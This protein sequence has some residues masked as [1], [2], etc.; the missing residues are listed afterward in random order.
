M[1]SYSIAGGFYTKATGTASHAEGSDSIASGYGAHAEGA[2]TEAS[3]NDS[4][5]Q[6]SHTIAA[7]DSQTA[8]GKY[9]DN[10]P[11][12]AFEVGNGTAVDA[13]SNAF[14]VDWDGNTTTAG[15]YAATCKASTVTL[16]TTKVSADSPNDVWSNGVCCTVSLSFKMNASWAPSGAAVI[17]GTVP[18]GYRP[19]TLVYITLYANA[20]SGGSG[21]LIGYIGSNGI[22]YVLNR[23][24]L[25]Y[26]ASQAFRFTATYAV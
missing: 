18:D 17:I 20:G 9:N 22:I 25:T 13:R 7:S 24:T 12:N 19:R 1:G 15:L 26:S 3:G 10:D 16:D 11:N 23:S 21:G 4:H 14:T 5:A 2:V 8:I 6:N